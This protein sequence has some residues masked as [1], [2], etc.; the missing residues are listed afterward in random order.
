MQDEMGLKNLIQRFFAPISQLPS[1]TKNKGTHCTHVT[2][3]LQNT[4]RKLKQLISDVRYDIYMA[5]SSHVRSALTSNKNNVQTL[6]A[7]NVK[8]FHA[9]RAHVCKL[10]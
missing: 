6:S 5:H 7:F 4:Q 9:G 10:N 3:K 1:R 8:G 2:T